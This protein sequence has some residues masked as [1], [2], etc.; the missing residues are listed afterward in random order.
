MDTKGDTEASNDVAGEASD[1]SAT[2][3]FGTP[4]E[5][6]SLEVATEDASATMDVN[7]APTTTS[8]YLSWNAPDVPGSDTKYEYRYRASGTISW[9]EWAS[10]DSENSVTVAN[11]SS[12]TTYDFQVRAVADDPTSDQADDVL[13]GLPAAATGTTA[14]AAYV[15]GA[16]TDLTAAPYLGGVVLSWTPPEVVAGTTSA[17]EFYRYQV[18][19]TSGSYTGAAV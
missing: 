16:P 9:T 1:P 5:P 19:T 13:Q 12:G 10:N 3:I 7:E 4:T 8:V 6:K 15:P 18:S 11:L 17:A 2:F 14:G